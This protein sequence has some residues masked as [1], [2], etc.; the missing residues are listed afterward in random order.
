MLLLREIGDQ[1]KSPFYLRRKFEGFGLRYISF[2]LPGAHA[3]R[4]NPAGMKQRHEFS[5]TVTT[6]LTVED[7]E[8]TEGMLE[9]AKT[10]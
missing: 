2:Q 4:D 9:I 3:S 6:E 8:E 10:L 7:S 5:D 1:R